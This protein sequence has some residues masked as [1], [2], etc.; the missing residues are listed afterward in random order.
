MLKLIGIMYISITLKNV[1][2]VL[3]GT[4][5]NYSEVPQVYRLVNLEKEI[6]WSNKLGLLEVLSIYD[7]I[8]FASFAYSMIYLV[9]YLISSLIGNKL[10][11]QIAY[12]VIIYLLTIF[13][14][15]HFKVSFLFIIIALFLGY[16]NWWM[17]K[18]WIKFV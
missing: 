8:L 15:D 16:A 2:Q 13:Y 11:F 4:L 9:L 14:F 18:K 7:Y 1:L 12:T 17:F 10:W 3:L 6:S 5:S